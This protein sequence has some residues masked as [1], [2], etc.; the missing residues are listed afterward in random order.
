MTPLLRW[1][2]WRI[3]RGCFP[4]FLD[5]GGFVWC[6][7]GPSPGAAA[8]TARLL[9][10][11][12]RAHY[13]TARLAAFRLCT[14]HGAFYAATKRLDENPTLNMGTCAFFL[15]KNRAKGGVKGAP[16]RLI[17]MRAHPIRPLAL[18]HMRTAL[19]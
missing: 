15:V 11:P 18:G 9:L 5:P 19:R 2:Y 12:L 13:R 6:R 14:K 7:H 3:C 17:K 8:A 16:G 1:P 10:P 4:A